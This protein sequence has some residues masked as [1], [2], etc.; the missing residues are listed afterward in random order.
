MGAMTQ[1]LHRIQAKAI[2]CSEG[3]TQQKAYSVAT[4]YSIVKDYIMLELESWLRS[5]RTGTLGSSHWY[6]HHEL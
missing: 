1:P 4:Y 2:C 3:I 6:V 5:T